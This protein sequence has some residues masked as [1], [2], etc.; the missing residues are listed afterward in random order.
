MKRLA[1]ALLLVASMAGVFFYVGMIR[2]SE[3]HRLVEA[4]DAALAQH[5]PFRAIEAFSG[6]IALRG[7]AML[8]HLKR[9][10]T[11]YERGDL[12]AALRDL[13][14]A[15]VLAP[16]EA[17]P[18]EA[19]GDVSREL[20]RH[21]DAVQ[22]YAAYLALD[23]DTPR[24]LYKLALSHHHAGRGARVIPLLR[25]AIEL[26]PNM[27]EAKYLLGL[28]LRGQD[29]QEEAIDA[30][31]QAVALSPGFTTAREA[32]EA[33]LGVAGRGGERIAQLEALAALEPEQS[34]HD[35]DLGLAYA[36]VG[37]TDMAVLSLG[38]ASEEHPEE[39]QIYAALGRV[40]LDIAGGANGHIALTKSLE[41]LR[42]TSHARASSEALTLLARALLLAEEVDEAVAL[43][44]LATQRYP[45]DPS[46]FLELATVMEHA[47]DLVRARDLLLAHDAITAYLPE[48]DRLPRLRR[49]AGLGRELDS[50]ANAARDDAPPARLP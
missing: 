35:V 12:A 36:A 38:R 13:T 6:A 41:A 29:R 17:R 32:L 21:D 18:L 40:W 1:L 42:S 48:E 30:L 8:A 50:V 16:G 5:D 19:L 31:R 24:V 49:I 27:A 25:R 23:E 45:V 28:A 2:T 10:E 46:A 3:Y 44:E 33:V 22:Q 11:Y 43:L 4:G 39:A 37:R 15:H 26:S 14:Q 34:Q 9:G 20:G 47:G 7:D